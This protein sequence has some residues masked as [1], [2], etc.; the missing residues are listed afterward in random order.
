[1]A[2]VMRCVDALS[3]LQPQEGGGTN[4]GGREKL[5]AFLMKE[6]TGLHPSAGSDDDCR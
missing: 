6:L 1:M 4:I 2:R 3:R 5:E